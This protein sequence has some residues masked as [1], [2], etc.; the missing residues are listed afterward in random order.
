MRNYYAAMEIKRDAAMVD[1]MP[2][3]RSL[4]E[5]EPNTAQKAQS[6]LLIEHRKRMYDRVHLQYEAISLA[7]QAF[8]SEIADTNDWDRRLVEFLPA[9]AEEE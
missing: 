4:S 3:L 1:I 2:N 5:Q 9:T 8:E 6:I 7:F